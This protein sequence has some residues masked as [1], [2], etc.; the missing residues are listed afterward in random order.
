MGDVRFLLLV[1]ETVCQHG[2]AEGAAARDGRRA[3][4]EELQRSLV[5]DAFGALLF[6][7]HLGA[8]GSA[9]QPLLAVPV[10]DLGELEAF[11]RLEDLPRGV[12]D[13][14]VAAKVAAV[15]VDNLALHSLRRHQLARHE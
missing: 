5:I 4:I 14:V 3:G 2:H 15:V 1:L 6:H 12:V 9:A 7:E 8:A 11:D 10:R 13:L